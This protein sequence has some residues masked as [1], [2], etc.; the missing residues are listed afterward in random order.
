MN[1]LKIYCDEENIKFMASGSDGSISINLFSDNIEY[2]SEYAI[3][4]DL[5]LSLKYCNKYINCFCKFIKCSQQIC[6][7]FI[8]NYPLKFE[9]LFE[10]PL[11][12]MVFYLAPKINDDD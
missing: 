5:K 7:Q 1:H 2:I 6:M 3:E 11:I 12:S 9:Y 10:D 4:E 8:D